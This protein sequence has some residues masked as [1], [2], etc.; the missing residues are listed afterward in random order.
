MEIVNIHSSAVALRDADNHDVD[1]RIRGGIR[2]DLPAEW[3]LEPGERLLITPFDP[4][5]ERRQLAAFRKHRGISHSVKVA[6][7]FL[8]RLENSGDSILL[9]R[10]DFQL[11]PEANEDGEIP[12]VLVDFVDYLVSDPWPM[13]ASANQSLQRIRNNRFGSEPSNWL[14]DFPTPGKPRKNR[15]PSILSVSIENDGV[16]LEIAFNDA[17]K[18]SVQRSEQLNG[19][20]EEIQQIVIES[21]T[22]SPVEVKDPPPPLDQQFYRIVL[23]P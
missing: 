1:W 19:Q 14:Y 7:P 17:G 6:G 5:A 15:A 12:F 8:G 21:E 2:F 13:P 16:R 22:R 11:S 18:Y 9:D 23:L 4:N 10:P 3:V 20:W